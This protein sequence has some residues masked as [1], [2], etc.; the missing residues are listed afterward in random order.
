VD[1]PPVLSPPEGGVSLD[2]QAMAAIGTRE[3]QRTVRARSRNDLFM[4]EAVVLTS[5][6]ANGNAF[7]NAAREALA[8]GL[9]IAASLQ[10]AR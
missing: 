2:E 6:R 3:K 9:K 10:A 5:G 4:T 1:E 7:A 8:S